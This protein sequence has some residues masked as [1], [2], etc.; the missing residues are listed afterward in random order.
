[1][2]VSGTFE[3]TLNPQ[4][5]ASDIVS[6]QLGRMTLHKRYRGGLDASS[7]GEMLSAAGIVPGCA[8][9]VALERVNGT[10]DGRRGSFVLQHSGIMDHGT[11][12]LVVWVVPGSGTDQLTGLSGS[13]GIQIEGG[14]H[15]YSFDYR[16]AE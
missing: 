11:A 13:L 10:L 14:E 12:E 9:Y 2:Q 3:V 1:M 16:L 6:A 15:R 4:D 5:A 7:L 8:G